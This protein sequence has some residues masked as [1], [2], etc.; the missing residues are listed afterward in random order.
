ML[1]RQKCADRS[2]N[3]LFIERRGDSERV[4]MTTA[5]GIAYTVYLPP[6]GLQSMFD[7]LLAKGAVT[8]LLSESARAPQQ[9]TRV[10]RRKKS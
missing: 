3:E 7:Q 6:N 8:A 9:Y 1:Y 5:A 2:G 4:H 10:D